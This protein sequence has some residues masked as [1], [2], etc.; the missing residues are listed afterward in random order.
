MAA[1]II[2]LG[3]FGTPGAGKSTTSKIIEEYCTENHVPM[4]RIKLADPLYEAQKAIYEIAGRQLSDFY[5][6]DGE[7]LN[8]LGSYLRKLNPNVLLDRFSLRLRD[9]IEKLDS[10]GSTS[11]VIVC[12][13]LRRPD[14][15]FLRTKDFRFVRII[16]DPNECESRRRARGDRTLGSASHATEQG[17]DEIEPDYR[18]HNESTIE[19]LRTQV[20]RFMGDTL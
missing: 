17:L 12:D 19:D 20:I 4:I 2:Q 10:T 18:I 15:E 5:D 8:F 13:D 3:L 1:K 14:A 6:Q 7:L 16:A 9:A 11:G